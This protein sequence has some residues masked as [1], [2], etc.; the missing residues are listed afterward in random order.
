MRGVAELGCLKALTHLDMLGSGVEEITGV[1]EL[2]LLTHLR[3]ERC[4]SLKGL[5]WMG[6][7]RALVVLEIRFSGVEEIPGVEYLVSLESLDCVFSRV[8]VLPELQHLPRLKRVDVAYTPMQCD[9]SSA[10]YGK[11]FV[12]FEHREGRIDF[13][14]DVAI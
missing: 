6:H 3:L 5:P 12:E 14:D 11:D 2:R 8:K 9:P 1:Q 10:Y 13:V 4:M 7:L